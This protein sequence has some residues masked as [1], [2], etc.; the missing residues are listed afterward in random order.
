MPGLGSVSL[1]VLIDFD[2]HEKV[3]LLLHNK[4][5]RNMFGTQAPYSLRESRMLGC[6]CM[7]FTTPW[8]IL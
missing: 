4:A 2:Y 6:W 3:G 5:E 7:S 1:R 8:G